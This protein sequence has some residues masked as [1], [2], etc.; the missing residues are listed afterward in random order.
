MA[1]AVLPAIIF[2]PALHDK[3]RD[4]T[5]IYL[6]GLYNS[7]E[8]GITV[9]TGLISQQWWVN[10]EDVARLHVGAR[11]FEDVKGKRLLGLTDRYDVNQLLDTMH[12]IDPQRNLVDKIELKEVR[13]TA[14]TEESLEILKKLGIDGWV[15][16]DETIRANLE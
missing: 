6:R 1:N 9:M 16:Y 12:E 15:A 3:L 5:N 4:S 2:G 11:I 7:D 8:T 13:T 10:V 14:E